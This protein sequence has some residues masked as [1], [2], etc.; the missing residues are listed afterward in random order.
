MGINSFQLKVIACLAMVADHVGYLFYP[1]VTILRMA[2]RLAFPIFAFLIA[3]GYSRTKNIKKYLFR[4]FIFF[5]VSQPIYGYIFNRNGGSVLNIFASLFLGLTAIYFYDKNR[6]KYHGLIIVCLISI[7]ASAINAA[8]GFLGV[9]MIFSFY[10]YDVKESFDKLFL[11]QLMLIIIFMASS[12]S[13]QYSIVHIVTFAD[14]G[15]ML[16]QLWFL[17]ALYIIKMYNGQ[18]GRYSK[19]FFYAFYPVHLLILG[20]IAIP[21]SF[22]NIFKI[23]R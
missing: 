18:R 10:F 8:Y 1:D 5:V 17:S 21:I 7:L 15:W 11:T 4:L 2:G 6:N 20:V 12:L 16:A 13:Y 3:E 23:F 19:Y 22:I 14:V 9:L